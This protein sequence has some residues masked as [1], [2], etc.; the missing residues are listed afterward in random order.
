MPTGQS[1]RNWRTVAM[2]ARAQVERSVAVPESQRAC[3]K[4]QS[5]CRRPISQAAFTSA[6]STK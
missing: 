3:P 5:C 2:Y 1:A 4:R 6:P